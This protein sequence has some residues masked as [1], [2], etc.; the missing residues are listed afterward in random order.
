MCT[1][2]SEPSTSSTQIDALTIGALLNA[3][4]SRVS[5][6]DMIH[7]IYIYFNNSST[8]FIAMKSI[9]MW[10]DGTRSELVGEIELF[11]GSKRGKLQIRG[12][13]SRKKRE[14]KRENMTVLEGTGDK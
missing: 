2:V 6:F 3:L 4:E 12:R 9:L 10:V 11:G 14:R 7:V 5:S 1:H 13:G 8:F